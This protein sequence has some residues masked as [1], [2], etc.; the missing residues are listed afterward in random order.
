[1]N[2]AENT[3]NAR[4]LPAWWSSD[5]SSRGGRTARNRWGKELEVNLWSYST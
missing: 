1:M 5:V 2:K 4:E 3:S